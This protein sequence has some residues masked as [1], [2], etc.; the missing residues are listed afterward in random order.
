MSRATRRAFLASAGLT[1]TGA[2]AANTPGII[3]CQSHLFVPELIA[4]MEKRKKSPYVYRKDGGT[5]IAVNDWVRR[6]MP[7]HT[8]V[9]AKLADMDGAGIAMTAL[10]INDPGPEL[11]GNDGPAVA[12]IAHDWIAEVA[13]K[14]PGRFFG[15]MTLPLQNIDAALEEADRGVQKLG[16]KGILLYSNINGEFPDELK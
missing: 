9:D 5:Y 14:H 13:R 11:F 3:D 2:A 10:S 7:K 16:M 15:L 8:D 6:L 1:A 12:R 4:L